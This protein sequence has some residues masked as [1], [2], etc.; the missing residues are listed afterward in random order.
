MSTAAS[1]D[2][3]THASDA[4]FEIPD[5]SA[6]GV[7]LDRLRKNLI[8]VKIR[9][10]D[11]YN[12]QTRNLLDQYLNLLPLREQN[13]IIGQLDALVQSCRVCCSECVANV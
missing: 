2:H 1:Q 9:D 4:V 6:E 5:T 8:T 11:N 12:D 3:D 10:A 13:A 7:L